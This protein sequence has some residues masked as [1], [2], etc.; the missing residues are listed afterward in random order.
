MRRSFQSIILAGSL[1]GWTSLVAAEPRFTKAEE[2]VESRDAVLALA[3]ACEVELQKPPKG[4]P[5]CNLYSQAVARFLRTL[6]EK[7]GWC[8]DQ[9]EDGVPMSEATCPD[10]S[11]Y[12]SDRAVVRINELA[13]KIG[14]PK[15]V[16]PPN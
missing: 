8:A 3:D 9:I 16:M 2:L 4:V 14:R 12:N 6:A 13:P 7:N 5:V 15:F 11:A 10:P 1:F